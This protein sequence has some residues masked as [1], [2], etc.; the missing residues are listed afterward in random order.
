MGLFG[1]GD[2][3]GGGIIPL[4]DP[5][6]KN[7]VAPQ[8]SYPGSIPAAPA[9]QQLFKDQQPYVTTTYQPPQDPLLRQIS[10]LEAT[11]GPRSGWDQNDPLLIQ[12]RN[13]EGTRGPSSGW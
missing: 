4:N 7:Y 9:F 1:T 13:L 5:R 3:A 6:N 12:L 10:N 2:C 11:R 8:D